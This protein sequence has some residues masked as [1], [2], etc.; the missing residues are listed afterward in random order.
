MRRTRDEFIALWRRHLAGMALYGTVS[1]MRDGPLVRT[2]KILDIP[3]EVEN[4]L[5]RMFD[6]LKPEDAPLP[7]KVS[8]GQPNP[9]VKR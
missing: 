3:A 4:L 5:G 7:V 9:M 1:E 2:T 8:N 6:S